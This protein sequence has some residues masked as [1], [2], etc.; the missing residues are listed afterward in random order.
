M[1]ESRDFFVSRQRSADTR[2]TDV[3]ALQR[4]L[5][6]HQNSGIL[7]STDVGRFDGVKGMPD[8]ARQSMPTSW[9]RGLM[10]S[11]V[12]SVLRGHSAVSLPII[13]AILK[14]LDFICLWQML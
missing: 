2:T 13:E 14:L 3:V 8:F 12:N 9:V 5:I 6:Q 10:L 11:R 7:T 4:A 1:L